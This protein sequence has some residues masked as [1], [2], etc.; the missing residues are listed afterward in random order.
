MREAL[1][2]AALLSLDTKREPLAAT[3]QGAWSIIETLSGLG[4]VSTPGPDQLSNPRLSITPLEQFPWLYEWTPYIRAS[5][6]PDLLHYLAAAPRDDYALGIRA[7]IWKEVAGFEARSFFESQLLKSRLEP[8]WAVD[9]DYV[10]ASTTP[11]LSLGQWRYVAWAAVR[12]GGSL[13]QQFGSSGHPKVREGVYRQLQTRVGLARSASWA[14][15]FSSCRTLPAN[16]YGR[17]FVEYLCGMGHM[18]WTHPPH[19]DNIFP[20]GQ[21]DSD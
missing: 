14:A 10:Y 5:L 20:V 15:N 3:S 9:I 18:F 8:G 2:L 13:A 16:A 11:E 21:A 1:A 17:I 4:V 7:R 19:P 6:L 12:H